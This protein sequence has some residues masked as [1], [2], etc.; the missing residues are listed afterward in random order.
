MVSVLYIIHNN[1]YSQVL[2]CFKILNN[3]MNATYSEEVKN[4]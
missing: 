1:V 4:S 3:P 2:I